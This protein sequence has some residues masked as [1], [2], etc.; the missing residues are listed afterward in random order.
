M[1]KLVYIA[2]AHAVSEWPVRS[3]RFNR[4]RGPVLIQDQA[5]T[6]AD[7][8][9]L[10]RG[11]ASSFNMEIDTQKGN[12]GDILVDNPDEG[13]MFERLYAPWPL[14]FYLIDTQGKLEWIAQPHT[15]SYDKALQELFG[16]LG[17]EDKE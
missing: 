6:G 3:A 7:R 10:A 16:L 15:C 5:A 4:G 12:I 8:C 17:L 11:F 13:D 9:K 14:R 1:W 2:E